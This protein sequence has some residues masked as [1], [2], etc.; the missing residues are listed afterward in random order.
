MQKLNFPSYSFR[1]K[2]RENIPLI[3]DEIRKKFVVLKPE[4]WVRQH[5]IK[6]LTREKNYPISHIN[7]ERELLVHGI[8]KRYDI[9]VYNSDGTIHLIVECK[10]PHIKIDQETFDQ[11]ARYNLAL[12]SEF[13][14][15]TNGLE[16]FYCIMDYKSESYRFLKEIP[17]FNK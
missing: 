7:A 8:K 2:S 10:A 3:F 9:V 11:I 17:N 13:L 5:C 14:M 15:I 6:F 1:F 4:E 12:R 16:H